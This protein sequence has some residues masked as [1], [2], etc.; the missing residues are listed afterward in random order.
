M[1]TSLLLVSSHWRWETGCTLTIPQNKAEVWPHHTL[2][3]LHSDGLFFCNGSKSHENEQWV[4]HCAVCIFCVC[5]FIRSLIRLSS[6]VSKGTPVSHTGGHSCMNTHNLFC[7]SPLC[8]TQTPFTPLWVTLTNK[9][10]SLWPVYT[11]VSTNSWDLW[12]GFWKSLS[13]FSYGL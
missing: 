2:Y 4:D 8:F 12:T 3:P 1:T 10:A 7:L 11:D 13:I 6:I 9:G 5:V